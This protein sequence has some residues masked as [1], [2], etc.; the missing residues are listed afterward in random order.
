[1]FETW[2]GWSNIF[3]C[4]FTIIAVAV[5]VVTYI[6]ST[7]SQNLEYKIRGKEKFI[8]A[9]MARYFTH[10]NTRNSEVWHRK[11]TYALGRESI[12]SSLDDIYSQSH[13]HFRNARTEKKKDLKEWVNIDSI[14]DFRKIDMEVRAYYKIWKAPDIRSDE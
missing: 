13:P 5:M 9:F 4:L 12:W 11:Q 10:V 7:Y 14:E 6:K 3:C 8:H 1:M 2:V